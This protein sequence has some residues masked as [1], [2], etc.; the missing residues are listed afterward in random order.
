MFKR[1]KALIGKYR[2][3]AEKI[4]KTRVVIKGGKV[5][6]IAAISVYLGKLLAVKTGVD[7]IYS[8]P[9]IAAVIKAVENFIKHKK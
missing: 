4:V 7:P 8:V 1:I 5:G 3:P 9:V 6:I 2:K